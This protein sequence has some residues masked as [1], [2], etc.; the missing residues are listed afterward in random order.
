MLARLLAGLFGI[1]CTAGVYGTLH[2]FH[3]NDVMATYITFAITG[4][5]IGTMNERIK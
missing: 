3:V 1:C 5:L 2:I 4:F